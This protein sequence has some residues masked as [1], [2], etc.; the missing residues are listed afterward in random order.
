MKIFAAY[1]STK[2]ISVYTSLGLPPS[3]IYIVG[4]PT[5]K[6]QHQCQVSLRAVSPLYF[7]LFSKV[8]Y[9]LTELRLSL[10]SSSPMAT[11][12]TFPSWSTI[13]DRDPP[14]PA[15][16][17]WSSGRAVSGWAAAATSCG[18][19]ITCCAP[20]PRNPR[21]RRRPCTW[22]APNVRRANRNVTA[23]GPN[24]RREA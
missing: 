9:T 23:S 12:L 15:A 19:A 21:P 5:K 22:A 6:L 1:G 10:H 14:R 11:R 13:R 17:A 24:A 18:S 7:L 8:F 2:D 20:S 16:L 3:Q 4:R